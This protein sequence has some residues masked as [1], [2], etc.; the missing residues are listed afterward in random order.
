MG[1]PPLF[2]VA[3]GFSVSFGD[4]HCRKRMVFPPFEE[5]VMWTWN[6][7]SPDAPFMARNID[8]GNEGKMNRK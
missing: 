2:A 7:R 4:G 3:P 6:T 8:D 1:Y 5:T